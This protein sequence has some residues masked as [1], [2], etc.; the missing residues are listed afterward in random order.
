MKGI[1]AGFLY[2]ETPSVH[3]HTLKVSILEPT[4]P[5]AYSYD[6]VK[7]E[8]GRR[9]HLL[10]PFRRRIVRVPFDFHHP[11]WIEDPDFDID[12]HVHRAEIAAPRGV[13]QL[14]ELIGEIAS[15]PLDRRH[16]LWELWFLEGLEQGRIVALVKLHHSVADGTAAA[17]LLANVMATSVEE[18]DPPGPTAPWR[19]EEIPS[20]RRLLADAWRDHLRQLREL[21]PLVRR[22]IRNAVTTQRQRQRLERPPPLP[23]LD[24]P[25]TSIN[26]ALT[27]RRGFATTTLPLADIKRIKDAAGV[28]VND[29]L[30][31]LVAGSLREYLTSRNEL[32][33]RPL[34]AEV[35]ISTDSPGGPLRLTGNR[36]S[37]IFTSLATDVADP[38]E[39]LWTIHSITEAAKELEAAMGH[40]TYREWTEYVPPRPFAW[41]MR[42]Y[43]RSKLARRSRP[44]I[45]VIVSS[46]RGPSLPLYA[47]G[48]RLCGL[49]SVGPILEGVALNVTAW[50]Y[51][52]RLHIAALVCPDVLADPHEITEGLHAALAEQLRRSCGAD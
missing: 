28:T 22:T 15:S 32:P 40:E 20:S 9:L 34:V 5:G 47:A 12:A 6:R 29:V 52:D 43:S 25:R 21:S 19:P 46:V 36:V 30:L 14:E 49:Y 18:I 24:A 2:M 48:M 39:R 13:R 4:F 37:N 45:N 27:P 1:D 35:P 31:A 33:S 26:S 38:A 11:V 7:E 16:P 44:P 8:V 41:L 42:M 23:L 3:M 50:S 10:P 17:H 51:L